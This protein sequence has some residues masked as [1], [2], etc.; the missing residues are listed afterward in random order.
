MKRVTVYTLLS[1]LIGG[2]LMFNGIMIFLGAEFISGLSKIIPLFK[3][4]PSPQHI[5][6]LLGLALLS[7]SL[8]TG[9]GAFERDR[10]R[11]RHLSYAH[12]AAS[13][14]WV[15]YLWL[16]IADW[17][18]LGKVLYPSAAT[19]TLVVAALMYAMTFRHAPVPGFVRATSMFTVFAFV[20]CSI[21]AIDGMS[22]VVGSEVFAKFSDWIPALGVIPHTIAHSTSLLGLALMSWAAL[23][24]V[25]STEK[26]R[27]RQR[28]YSFAHLFVTAGWTLYLWMHARDWNLIGMI[29]YPGIAT[30]MLGVAVGLYFASTTRPPV[31]DETPKHKQT[32]APAIKTAPDY[33]TNQ[34]RA[35]PG[36]ND[37][38]RLP[39]NYS[40]VDPKKAKA[41]EDDTTGKQFRIGTNEFQTGRRRGQ[42]V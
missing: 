30:A 17:A 8:F 9:V 32:M 3:V 41:D 28:Q 23:V 6:A 20:I 14:L 33:V 5:T 21:L 36:H 31:R 16:R 4:F 38:A 35:K 11:Q 7:Y 12:I 10:R 40:Y 1:C 22:M 18:G 2:T 42:R 26:D 39:V 24:F 34:G 37:A 25:A 27:H 19:G 13:S 15:G 29:L